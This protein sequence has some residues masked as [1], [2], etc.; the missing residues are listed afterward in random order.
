MGVVIYFPHLRA[1]VVVSLW[2]L[3]ILHHLSPVS[4]TT[5]PHIKL[6]Q[7][8]EAPMWQSNACADDEGMF[9]CF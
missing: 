2:T 8:Q 4:S 5:I 3:R 9:N 6:D 7:Q 1:S